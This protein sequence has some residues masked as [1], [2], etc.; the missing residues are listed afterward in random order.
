M[1]WPSDLG[2]GK[3]RGGRVI[4]YWIVASILFWGVVGIWYRRDTAT[5]VVLC[6]MPYCPYG[7]SAAR[8]VLTLLDQES[9]ANFNFCYLANEHLSDP[10]ASSAP[11]VKSSAPNQSGCEQI[12]TAQPDFGRF[13]SLH[14]RQETEESVRQVVIINRWPKLFSSYLKAFLDDPNGTWQSRSEVAGIPSSMLNDLVQ[15]PAGAKWFSEN[16]RQAR[17]MGITLSPT[18]VV[19][20]KPLSKFPTSEEELRM[21]LCS[22]GVLKVNCQGVLCDTR[23]PCPEKHGYVGKCERGQCVYQL[24]QQRHD[25]VSAWLIIPED[26]V[27]AEEFPVGE[28]IKGWASYL[29]LTRISLSDPKAQ[30]LL[31]YSKVE[32]F[33]VLVVEGSLTQREWGARCIQ[34]LS[35]IA[36]QNRYLVSFDYSAMPFVSYARI[37]QDQA[38][39]H[40]KPN[41]Y[42]GA[43]FLH[44]MG[45]LEAAAKSYRLTLTE[46]PED[47]RAWNNLGAI[48]YDSHGMRQSGSAM[49]QRAVA[50]NAAY[51]PALQNLLR[52]ALDRKDAKA[53]A[54]AKERL[55][56]VAI[57]NKH[58]REATDLLAEVSKEK[59]LEFSARKGLAFVAV[60]E[61][62]PQ[63]A[64]KD[65]ERCLEI[66]LQPD[67]DFANQLAGVYFRLGDRAKAEDWY[68]RAVSGSAPSE[69]AYPN[70]CHLLHSSGQ[71]AKLLS[72]SDRAFS[73]YPKNSTFGFYKAQALAHLNRSEDAIQLFKQLG[74]TSEEAAFQ[75]SYE[76]AKLYHS[77]QEKTTATRYARQ[78]VRTVASQRQSRLRDECMEIGNLALESGDN[79]LAAEAFQQVLRTKPSDVAAH[80]LLAACYNNLGQQVRSQEH[81]TLAKQFG[82]DA[83]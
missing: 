58:W 79:E 61:S 24:A 15:S 64:I 57:R 29:N 3:F 21:V 37:V 31:K 53:I 33:P 66:N 11:S 52:C 55:G 4:L 67:G 51:E 76:L 50:L 41:H 80:K 6:I 20:G 45:K 35:L 56:W 40:V 73:L 7:Q 1:N 83:E 2:G 78:F 36:K 62:R 18:L 46:N 32:S 5:N 19:N 9:P 60:Q 16:I 42:T 30:E 54:V 38:G 49:F 47:Y 65:L 12:L 34:E 68:E 22:A 82:G 71:W 63:D 81:L 13:S 75:S 27:P 69:Q 44:Q 28:A 10:S 14:G 25:A 72:V 77:Q 43:L 59:E 26:C 17:E 48:L 70:L 8:D 74:Q 39:L 23:L